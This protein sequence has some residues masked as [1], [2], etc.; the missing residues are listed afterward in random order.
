VSVLKYFYVSWL[1]AKILFTMLRQLFASLA[2]SLFVAFTTLAQQ[3]PTTP[4]FTEGIIVYDL[5]AY[6]VSELSEFFRETTLTVYIKDGKSKLD[7]KIMGGFADMQ[8]IQTSENKQ[9]A[10]L[11]VPM[12]SEKV[13][14]SLH[15]ND[16]LKQ[17]SVGINVNK[18]PINSGQMSYF[19]NE[20]RR[21]IGK[22]CYKAT[23]TI[24]GTNQKAAMYLA[25]KWQMQTPDYLSPYIGILPAV[26][27]NVEMNIEGLRLV[28]TAREMR[29]TSVSDKVFEIPEDYKQ[30]TF[31]ELK[32]E[33]KDIFGG[34]R[35]ESVGL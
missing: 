25:K 11:N 24:A 27:M 8:I 16:M 32:Q 1:N 9:V 14:V 2:L 28:L 19:Y 22:S 34:T 20:K 23:T 21:I 30:R 17:L 6:G 13:V 26:P 10:L 3:A 18:T 7:L 31:S 12:L 29:R 15:E 33:V 35:K 4:N 5:K